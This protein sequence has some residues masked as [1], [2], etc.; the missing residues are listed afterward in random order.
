MKTGAPVVLPGDCW[1]THV[2]FETETH[3]IGPA[4]AGRVT[5]Y[6]RA[7]RLFDVVFSLALLSVTAV[8]ALVLLCLNPFFN[9]GPLFYCQTRMGKDCLP[10]T[11]FKFR[12][13]QP[14]TDPARGAFDPL[15]HHRI[16]PL[17]QF[18]RVARIDELPQLVNVLRGHMSLIGPR[19]DA[20]DHAAEYLVTFPSYR[21]RYSVL[22][23]ISGL[24]QTEVGYVDGE[25]GI[26]AKIAADHY[27]LRNRGFRLD[28]WIFWRTLKTVAQRGGL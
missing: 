1:L 14:D 21:A 26:R 20:Y 25:A 13:M 4:D 16:T 17:G 12:S 7:K 15:E 6:E 2:P 23:G 9:R 19:P 28:C 8:V 22:P 24:A 5:P 10:F 27:Y 11:A 3:A 18:L